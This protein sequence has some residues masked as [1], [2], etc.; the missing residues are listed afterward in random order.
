MTF[1]RRITLVSAAAVAV[2]IALASIF[3]YILTS[4]QLHRQVDEQLRG[5][6]RA[7]VYLLSHAPRGTVTPRALQA[8]GASPAV[9]DAAGAVSGPSGAPL[10]VEGEEAAGIR[11]FPTLTPAPDEVRGYQQVVDGSGHVIYRSVTSRRSRSPP[12]HVSSRRAG[13]V[14]SSAP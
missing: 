5:R 6:S 8:A 4:Q 1:R 12:A 13:A 7:V 10:A 9:R 2:A 14:R 11:G 3:V